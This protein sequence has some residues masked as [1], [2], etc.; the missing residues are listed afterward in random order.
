MTEKIKSMSLSTTP[1]EGG[2]S[3]SKKRGRRGKLGTQ[4]TEGRD[5][6]KKECSGFKNRLG[7][8]GIEECAQIWSNGVREKKKIIEQKGR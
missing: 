8:H 5:K 1:T 3:L 4:T 2:T 6:K 7:K